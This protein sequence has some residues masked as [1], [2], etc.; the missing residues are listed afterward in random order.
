MKTS[1]ARSQSARSPITTQYVGIRFR[2]LSKPWRWLFPA[3]I[4]LSLTFLAVISAQAGNTW[5][6]GGGSTNWND[7][8]NWGGAAPGY[9]TLV[10]SGNTQTT[11]N[12]NSITAMNQVN[13]NGTAA[14][15]MNGTSTL[16]L[17]DNGGTQAKL[18]SL[19]TGGVTINAPITFA[20]N[21]S[22]FGNPNGYNPFGEINAVSSNIT[23]ASDTLTVN[24]SSVNGIKFFGGA[25]RDVTFASTVSAS[26]K[27]MGFTNAN[28]SSVTIA[29][30]AN[31]TVGD[32]YVMNGN[33]LNL[34]GGTLTTSAVRLGGDFGNTGNQNQTLGGTLALAPLTG[35]VSFSGIINTVTGNTSNALLIDSKNTSGTNML[36]GS[37]FL[38]SALNISQAA[39][40][41]LVITNIGG[42]L[43]GALTKSGLGTVILS[44]SNGYG[45]GTTI[46]AGTLVAANGLALGATSLPVTVNN[47]GTLQVSGGIALNNGY[48]FRL[49]TGGT[50]NSNG[51]NSVDGAITVQS[52][53][54][55]SATLSTTNASDVFS[56]GNF[57]N[58]IVGGIAGA[59]VHIAGSGT[60]LVNFSNSGGYLGGWS[61]DAGTLQLGHPAALGRSVADRVT[62]NGG[63]LSG[64]AG[65]D[66][67]FSGPAANGLTVTANSTLTSDRRI[68]GPGLT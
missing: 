19:G 54:T 10:F 42:N 58:D 23:F 7:N 67:T 45:N 62:L 8:N 47:S 21:N 48:E 57:E 24:G 17:F 32:F 30:G 26:G 29:T 3:P 40:G 25:G 18:E 44:N 50:I 9:G 2:P 63:N 1:Y 60:I 5:T 15:V 20:A 22:P 36:T 68:A 41:T 65:V 37:L 27:W 61:V 11:N 49:N 4:T 38:D 14:W 16:S 35:G 13:W 34:A 66:T 55:P 12:N 53:G 46:N 6:G 31:V 43:G 51:T 56:V 33:T 28:G 39:G 59:A 64:R 52:S